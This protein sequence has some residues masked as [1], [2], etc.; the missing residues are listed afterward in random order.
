M[1]A[2]GLTLHLL[3]DKTSYSYCLNSCFNNLWILGLNYQYFFSKTCIYEI[4]TFL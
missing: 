4:L 1:F 3:T 2:Q